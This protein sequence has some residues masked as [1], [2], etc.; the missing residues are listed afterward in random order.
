MA[1]LVTPVKGGPAHCAG[2]RAGD[3]I[4][5]IIKSEDDLGKP[6]IPP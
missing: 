5:Q 2:L 6:L 4:D 3:L 1:Q